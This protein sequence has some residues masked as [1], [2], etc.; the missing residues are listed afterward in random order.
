MSENIARSSMV[1]ARQNWPWIVLILAI[2]AAVWHDVDFPQ[3][4]DPEFP[5]IDRPTFSRR[6]P[7]AYR[8]AEPGDTID[9]VM[10]YLSSLAVV[11]A[12]LGIASSWAE[13]SGQRQRREIR[14]ESDP[15]Y[16]PT[17]WV[18]AIAISIAAFW[19]S[20]TPGPTY[21]GWHGF[22]WRTMFD[23]AAPARLRL[24][25]AAA[26]TI[27]ASSS[28]V[29]ILYNFRFRK[30]LWHDARERHVAGLLG[31]ALV[32]T[33]ARQFEI[34][35]VE[36]IGYWPRF[37]FVFGL[38]CW[39]AS[40]LRSLPIPRKL[41]RLSTLTAVGCIAWF[42]FVSLGVELTW[43]HR[44]LGRFKMIEPGRLYISAMPTYKGLEVAYARHHFKTII[45]L[46]PEDTPL[47]SPILPDELRF[48]REHGIKYIGSPS[49]ALSSDAFLS[50]TLRLANDP[51]AWPIL[52]HCHGCQDR[53]P[54]WLG[55]YRFLYKG[56]S[57]ASI[58]TDIER[59]RGYCPKGSVILLFNRV[60][61]QRAPERFEADP[62][63]RILREAASK[64]KDPYYFQLRR[65]QRQRE[66]SRAK[67][68]LRLGQAGLGP[69]EQTVRP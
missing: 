14:P 2:A 56:D 41:L 36:P 54:A 40:L 33:A 28:I 50:E 1:R 43:F 12:T 66:L 58:M 46:F 17:L 22:G 53:T 52:V 13:T 62:T 10:I 37:A 27:L 29:P 9:R 6:P 67:G 7:P 34:P 49:D 25:L 61:A 55:V 18:S 32:F 51:S 4:M 44:P 68:T 24:G 5:K 60:L 21:D 48:V 3:D 38:I 45:N 63:S 20:S 19:Y 11:F 31:L 35:G 69:S 64:T 8:L 42:A 15:A 57:L 59:H 47:R 39:N 65:E 30:D 26:A 16:K 23:Q